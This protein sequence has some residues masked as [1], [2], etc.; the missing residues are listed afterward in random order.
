MAALGFVDAIGLIGTGLG[1]IQFGLDNF[2]PDQEDPKGAIVGIKAGAGFGAADNLGGKISKVYAYDFEN[3]LIGTAGSQTMAGNGDYLTFNVDQDIP[4][5]QGQYIGI[6]NSKDATCISWIT[7]KM[8]DNS[9]GG[10]WTGDIGR[11][12]SPRCGHTWFESQE[13]AGHLD[14]GSLYRPSCTW[15]DGNHDGTIENAA[16]KFATYAY[17]NDTS[18]V[19]LD[20]DACA[21]TLFRTQEGE[22]TDAPVDPSLAGRSISSPRTRLPWM[23]S[24][25]VVSDINSHSATN[26]CNSETSWGPDF[27]DSHGKLCDMGTKTL[28]TLCSNENIDGC[29]EISTGASNGTSND[30]SVARQKRSIAKR[31]ISAE[32]KTYEKTDVWAGDI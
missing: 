25:L 21:S 6:Q 15:L 20:R 27:V 7:V 1:I 28:Y 10:A 30:V 17:G 22:I 9:V 18:H 12:P 19:T 29:V 14:D 11:S 31:T 5:L 2:V 26:L 32:L 3:K 8:H 24:K 16:L 23:E 4:G 13:V